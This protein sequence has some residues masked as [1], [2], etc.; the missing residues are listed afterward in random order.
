MYAEKLQKLREFCP[1]DKNDE[2]Q[3]VIKI[4]KGEK[5]DKKEE[6][7]I[8]FDIDAKQEEHSKVKSS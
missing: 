4:V 5:N 3:R 2:L 7:P 8:L 6:E 1:K